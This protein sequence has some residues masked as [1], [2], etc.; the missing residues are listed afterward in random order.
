MTMASP[1]GA[2]TP[3][4]LPVPQ[5]PKEDAVK[6]LTFEEVLRIKGGLPPTAALDEETYRAPLTTATEPVDYA[7]PDSNSRTSTPT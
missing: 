5:G 6:E 4:G 7:K 2:R 1:A 3:A